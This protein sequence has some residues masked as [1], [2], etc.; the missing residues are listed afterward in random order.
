MP[1]QIDQY[2]FFR[3]NLVILV[4]SMATLVKIYQNPLVVNFGVW[5]NQRAQTAPVVQVAEEED[6]GRGERNSLMLPG[7]LDTPL[8][9]LYPAQRS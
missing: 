1:T 8:L 4:K 3:G 9:S 2:S 6:G 7:G 5:S